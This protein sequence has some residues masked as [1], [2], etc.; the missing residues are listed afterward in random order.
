MTY[1]PEIT[2]TLSLIARIDVALAFHRYICS[3]EDK[4]RFSRPVLLDES[5]SKLPIPAFY[6]K[7]ALCPLLIAQKKDNSE[8]IANSFELDILSSKLT[9]LNG[10]NGSGKTTNLKALQ[11]ILT[12][13]QIG[14][15]VP[16]DKLVYSPMSMMFNRAGGQAEDSIAKAH[17]SFLQ[18]V[19]DLS[20]VLNNLSL[21]QPNKA[22][23]CLDEVGINTSAEQ[24]FP[25]MWSICEH[26]L[27]LPSTLVLISTHNHLL[28][29]IVST[30]MSTKIMRVN[31]EGNDNHKVE[32]LD[33]E[34]ES[35]ESIKKVN[36]INQDYFSPSFFESL[37][38]NKEFIE[39]N[40]K[41]QFFNEKTFNQT[42]YFG[43]EMRTKF[44]KTK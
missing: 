34:L 1:K 31:Y 7:N 32:E 8:L 11:L 43:K 13:A 28:S 29:K 10:A 17:S 5:D 3:Q 36:I 40:Y 4:V 21:V 30:Y 24:G 26:F 12:L 44:F 35:K 20:T 14:C 19:Q 33:D 22:F 42:S 9:I 27:N 15:Y 37:K 39:K 23:I 6:I 38:L 16:A 41:S 2:K 18:E 25:L